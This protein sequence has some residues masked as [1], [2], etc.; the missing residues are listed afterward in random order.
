MLVPA[1][2]PGS[3]CRV[4]HAFLSWVHFTS[5]P[6]HPPPTHTHTHTHTHTQ[7]ICKNSSPYLF[8]TSDN[9][10]CTVTHTSS[11]IVVPHVV[12]PTPLTDQST[13]KVSFITRTSGRY[14][15]EV[16]INGKNVGASPYSRNYTPGK[17]YSLTYLCLTCGID[18]HDRT[19]TSC[20]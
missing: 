3:N 4:A 5:L 1:L 12:E 15:I 19:Y 18:L 7:L 11:S 10:Q 16:K 13:L 6:T 14:S 20:F 9:F 17:L 8:Q 2:A